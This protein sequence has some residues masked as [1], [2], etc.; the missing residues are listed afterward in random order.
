MIAKSVFLFGGTPGTAD[1]AANELILRIPDLCVAGTRDRYA[2]ASDHE[3]V[4]DPI[5]ESVADIVLVALGAP[6]QEMWLYKHA[7]RLD[8]P[9]LLAIGALFGLLAESGTRSPHRR[10]RRDNWGPCNREPA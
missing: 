6:T 1:A 5:N 2:G 8:A 3:A 9:L 7:H 10:K 4:N